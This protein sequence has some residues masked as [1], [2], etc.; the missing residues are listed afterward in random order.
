MIGSVILNYLKKVHPDFSVYSQ[1]VR[2]DFQA[3]G[4]RHSP[5]EQKNKSQS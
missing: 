2:E 4:S 1:D 3:L 5:P